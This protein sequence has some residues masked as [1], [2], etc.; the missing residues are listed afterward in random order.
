MDTE[1]SSKF[2]GSLSK[3]LQSLCNGYVNF[4][5]G[6]ELIG[7]IY[8]SV[9]TGKKIDYILNEKVCKSDNSVTFISNS[10]HA[11]PLD[12][13]KTLSSKKNAE[14]KAPDG[15]GRKEEEAL[16]LQSG[17]GPTRNTQ[18]NTLGRNHGS[19]SSGQATQNRSSVKRPGSPL[20]SRKAPTPP[21]RRPSTPPS[22]R[23]SQLQS[24]SAKGSLGS[25][26]SLK[27]VPSS[28]SSSSLDNAPSPSSRLKTNHPSTETVSG[29]ADSDI[30]VPP[31]ILAV[32]QVPDLSSF[33]GAT[34]NEG[35]DATAHEQGLATSDD[36]T[37]PDTDITFI[38]EEFIPSA[39]SC[40]Q[41]GSSGQSSG[42]SM[43]EQVHDSGS[44]SGLYP[45]MLHQNTAAFSSSGGFPPSFPSL[46]NATATSTSTSQASTDIF[47]NP[48]PGTSNQ[49]SSS[50]D[51]SVFGVR[52]LMGRSGPEDLALVP[53]NSRLECFSYV[54]STSIILT[55]NNLPKWPDEAEA[56][57]YQNVKMQNIYSC[58]SCGIDLN[59]QTLWQDEQGGHILIAKMTH[60][61][62]QMRERKYQCEY[63]GKAFVAGRDYAVDALVSDLWF[64]REDGHGMLKEGEFVPDRTVRIA[65]VSPK[66][67][68]RERLKS[69]VCETSGHSRHI[70][71]TVDLM[72][73][74]M[75]HIP[76]FRHTNN[77]NHPLQETR[78]K[79]WN[80]RSKRYAS[81]R[82]MDSD[83]ASSYIT[84][85]TCGIRGSH[86]GC[87]K[88][89]ATISYVPDEGSRMRNL[90][91]MG[92]I[93][94]TLEEDIDDVQRAPHTCVQCKTCLYVFA[95]LSLL[96]SHHNHCVGIKNSACNL[97]GRIYSS[98]FALKEHLLGGG[99]MTCALEHLGRIVTIGKQ[100]LGD[101]AVLRADFEIMNAIDHCSV[102]AQESELV[103]V[104]HKKLEAGIS[105]IGTAYGEVC[106]IR[107]GHR[108]PVCW[109]TFVQSGGNGSIVGPTLQKT[110]ENKYI[111]T[112]D[113]V[114]MLARSVDLV[115]P[116]DG[117]LLF[118]KISKAC[119]KAHFSLS[120]PCSSNT[121]AKKTQYSGT[122][123]RTRVLGLLT[124]KVEPGKASVIASHAEL[125]KRRASS[126]HS[127]LPDLNFGLP[128]PLP[129]SVPSASQPLSFLSSALVPGLP[130]HKGQVPPMMLDASYIGIFGGRPGRKCRR[131]GQEFLS[132]EDFE[133]H[134]DFCRRKMLACDYCDMCFRR[135]HGKDSDELIWI[136][137][138]PCAVPSAKQETQLQ[139]QLHL[140]PYADLEGQNTD[141]IVVPSGYFS[142]LHG[143]STRRRSHGTIL[144]IGLQNVL[145]VG[146]ET[147]T[148]ASEIIIERCENDWRE[149]SS[150][151]PFQCERCGQRFTYPRTLRRHWWKCSGTRNLECDISFRFCGDISLLRQAEDITQPNL[152]TKWKVS[153]GPVQC[154]ECGTMLSCVTALEAHLARA[155]RDLQQK[156]AVCDRCD[157]ISSLRLCKKQISPSHTWPHQLPNH[158]QVIDSENFYQPSAAGPQNSSLVFQEKVAAKASLF[159]STCR[160]SFVHVQ[161]LNRHKWKCQG[162]RMLVCPQCNYVTHRMDSYL[163]SQHACSPFLQLG[164]G[165]AELIPV[166]Q[167]SLQAT[168][169][170]GSYCKRCMF[171][172]SSVQVLF[173]HI[174]KCRAASKSHSK[175]G[176]AS[177][178]TVQSEN[179][180]ET[181]RG[182]QRL[183]TQEV[184]NATDPSKP[185]K[186]SRCGR[187]YQ[188]AQSL[189]RHRWNHCS[190][191]LHP[192]LL[193]LDKDSCRI[194]ENAAC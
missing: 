69:F 153:R 104:E 101:K 145:C 15:A 74:S 169:A 123:S 61:K 80:K 81:S 161:S 84:D 21:Q 50:G 7:H 20:T 87:C 146:K 45:V 90:R 184:D 102:S 166:Q 33:L 88:G 157:M 42:R 116:S 142:G 43:E 11:Q 155:H 34:G 71:Q 183:G 138:L 55:R 27:N 165:S 124:E 17:D 44:S 172:C 60:S 19:L 107:R 168:T 170:H 93:I 148:H 115:N 26:A 14:D 32:A 48:V 132:Q 96:H 193:S 194:G 8:L 185:Y 47:A 16:L 91:T 76:A 175:E 177:A 160:Q 143:F 66:K 53:V 4:E 9:D 156:P 64:R 6:V 10:F 85:L 139:D 28:P 182:Q 65:S 59:K 149:G 54:Q 83:W 121:K 110:P 141:R 24:A 62:W 136:E 100:F 191:V 89:G 111:G 68:W 31:N 37:K 147:E 150:L 188:L 109:K 117:L 12:K 38:K 173:Q 186:C 187:S 151:K 192:N 144:P 36:E 180:E 181:E 162:L 120:L 49:D 154:K 179:W 46:G 135:R 134:V 67:G 106:D 176:V 78:Q 174:S 82:M 25:P 112:D 86:D 22:Q 163:V 113:E 77:K 122:A 13:L 158:P 30:L 133:D 3:F 2:I 171:Y 178:V 40:A 98:R 140:A 18:I 95:E 126:G 189:Q 137:I 105:D 129:L 41:A 97:C 94:A 167:V 29:D 72:F 75:D 73:G 63:C 128:L 23:R 127:G 70:K 118:D 58:H 190:P 114:T 51:P 52:N 99:T 57:A 159:C 103:R 92:Q 79:P 35:Q 119:N 108:C 131:C 56:A 152:V 125:P 1:S 130:Q 5:D 39:S 164:Q